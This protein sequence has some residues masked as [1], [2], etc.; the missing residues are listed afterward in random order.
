MGL[1]AESGC[2]HPMVM[3]DDSADR[4]LDHSLESYVW[5]GQIWV[6]PV[7]A[8]CQMAVERIDLGGATFGTWDEVLNAKADLAGTV[9]PLLPVDAFDLM[10]TLLATAGETKL[11]FSDYDFTSDENGLKALHILKK[12]YLAGPSDA[13]KWNPIHVLEAM[14]TTN[15]F[16]FSPALFG[17]FNYAHPRFRDHVLSYV[18]LPRF[19]GGGPMRGILGGLRRVIWQ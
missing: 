6:M 5:K 1:I 3:P 13:V 4:S 19:A 16:R 8:A 7:D 2:L 17:Y 12:L 11:P 9:T 15:D 18:D 14:S 10:M